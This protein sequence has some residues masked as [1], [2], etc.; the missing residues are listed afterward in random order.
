MS[1]PKPRK[2]AQISD[3]ELANKMAEG[4][5]FHYYQCLNGLVDVAVPIVIKGEHIAN[6]FSGQFFFE[7]PDEAF[8]R[9]QAEKYGFDEESY[10]EALK[11]VPV[12]SKEKVQVAMDFLL[13]VTQLISEMA[14]QKQEQTELHNELEQKEDRLSKIMHGSKRRHVGLGFKNE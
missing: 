14:L 10:I 1:I 9:K 4:K 13:D 5:S 12:V 6:L 11:K 3:T 7:E 2:N 8:F